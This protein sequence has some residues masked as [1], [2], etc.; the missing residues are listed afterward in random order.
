MKRLVYLKDGIL[1]WR[2]RTPN[3]P[4]PD[5]YKTTA[6]LFNSQ[7]ADTPITTATFKC[8]GREYV[9]TDVINELRGPRHA[10]ND[11]YSATGRHD[12]ARKT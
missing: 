2:E 8:C 5:R 3:T 9:T 10:N 12:G 6:N 7:Y 11:D 1:Y 4:M